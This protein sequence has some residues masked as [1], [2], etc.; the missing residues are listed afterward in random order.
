V[1][2][3]KNSSLYEE[4]DVSF[5]N[6][7][8]EITLA[9]TLTIPHTKEKHTAVVLV[10][11]SG[12]NDRDST[13]LEHKPFA[14]IADH[15][16]KKGIIS[17]RF[18]KRGVGKSTGDY[19]TATTEDFAEDVKAAIGF[20]KSQKDV[21]P[22][23]IGL[24]GHSEGGLYTSI[25]AS[26]TNDL[27]FIVL[28]AGLVSPGSKNASA[29]F[30]LLV[31]ED[32]SDKSDHDDDRKLFDRFFDLV[33]REALSQEEREEAL[34]IAERQ[35]P[36]INYETKAVLGF[37]QLTPEIFVSIFSIPWMHAYLN[38]SSVSYLKQMKCPVLA[39]YGEKDVQVPARE[40]I[41]TINNKLGESET[42]NYS[43]VKIPNVN[44]LFQ[45]CETGYPSEYRKCKQSMVPEVLNIISD[46]ISEIT[47]N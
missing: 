39:I 34:K 25:A 32:N 30:T 16:A 46:W 38:S 2:F 33:R 13:F 8:S 29:V 28:L 45:Y 5:N 35:F 10:S 31:N 4:I 6:M 27:A 18:D 7:E 11:G 15:L 20:L 19:N 37:S 36:R 1:T 47:I 3:Q 43:I 14:I 42:S 21:D 17:L 9:G 24:I 23:Y 44:H 22:N 41:E 40:N 26:K 12:P